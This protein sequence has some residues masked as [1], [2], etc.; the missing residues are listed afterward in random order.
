[1]FSVST[2]LASIRLLSHIFCYPLLRWHICKVPLCNHER[3]TPGMYLAEEVRI[4]LTLKFR[5]TAIDTYIVQIKSTIGIAPSLIV[6]NTMIMRRSSLASLIRVRRADV[7][8]HM[9]PGIRF[10]LGV[11]RC[12]VEI[13]RTMDWHQL[14][15]RSLVFHVLS[16]MKWSPINDGRLLKTPHPCLAS[17]EALHC[18]PFTILCSVCTW[19]RLQI[20]LLL[21]TNNA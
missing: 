2:V 4:V 14:H 17:N 21:G 15:H 7:D 10:T 12:E 20:S 18:S 8:L 9:Y 6:K 1:M 11:W 19:L 16:W 13:L 3:E 5:W